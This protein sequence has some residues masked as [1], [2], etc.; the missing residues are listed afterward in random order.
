MKGQNLSFLEKQQLADAYQSEINKLEF[1]I[2]LLKEAVAQLMEGISADKRREPS[3]TIQQDV[4][5]DGFV[6]IKTGKRGRPRKVP[7]QEANKFLSGSVTNQDAT[8]EN[9]E[10]S[11]TTSPVKKSDGAKKSS[12]K[13]AT[14]STEQTGPKKRG[15][16][17]NQKVGGYRLSE[18]DNLIINGIK[19]ADRALIKSELLE[20]A[21][22]K[23]NAEK[24]G[25]DEQELNVKISQSLHKLAN[26]RDDLVKVSFP[27]RGFAYA[28]P[29]WMTNKGELPRKYMR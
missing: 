2:N 6:T 12:Q 26:R 1:Q 9:V 24:L 16:K 25:M 7:V 10:D 17:P 22:A 11:K 4:S 15:R 18:W 19:S 8:E 29:S 21:F 28:I 14:S 5:S 3:K 20:L 27:G 13:S 23:N